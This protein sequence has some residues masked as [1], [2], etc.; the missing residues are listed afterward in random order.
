MI[1]LCDAGDQTH[2]FMHAG[3]VVYALSYLPGPWNGY[4]RVKGLRF[5]LEVLGQNLFPCLLRF[6]KDGIIP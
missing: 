1:E 3:Q 2:G 5:F 6:I 4:H